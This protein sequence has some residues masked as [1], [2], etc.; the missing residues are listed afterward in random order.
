MG[1]SDNLEK[2]GN[3]NRD[4]G[5]LSLR[6]VLA[7][8]LLLKGFRF[9]FHSDELTNV[10]STYNPTTIAVIFTWFV[11]LA[12]MVGGIFILIGVLTRA[13][14]IVQ[15]PILIG[16]MLL[17]LETHVLNSSEWLLAFVTFFL[18]VY[19]YIYGSGKFS[20]GYLLLKQAED[21]EEEMLHEHDISHRHSV[22]H[23][24]SSY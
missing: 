23:H 22:H 21:E 8:V 5:L 1:T 17:S 15:I 4:L 18:I 19:L 13:T 16:A 6:I 12:D 14:C 20:V 2:W 9:L 11:I 7:A 24:H 3:N 10:I